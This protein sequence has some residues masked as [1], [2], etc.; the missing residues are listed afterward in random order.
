MHS[1]V[2]CGDGILF[3]GFFCLWFFFFLSVCFGRRSP[4]SQISA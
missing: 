2:L 1:E 3:E 4:Q